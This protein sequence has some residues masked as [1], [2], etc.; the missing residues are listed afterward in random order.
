ML[1]PLSKL[2][3]TVML[4]LAWLRAGRAI[5]AEPLR[6]R[7]AWCFGLAIALRLAL[8]LLM[9]A[10]HGF[11]REAAA[12]L[13][14][15][16]GLSLLWPLLGLALAGPLTRAGWIT[17]IAFTVITLIVLWL[18]G[19]GDAMF[20]SWIVFT[21]CAW[22]RELRTGERF[23]ASLASLVVALA[24]LLGVHRADGLSRAGG[25]AEGVAWFTR[26]L[27]IV[28]ALYATTAAFK[29]FTQD[30]TLGVRRVSRRLVLSHVLVLFVP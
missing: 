26:G 5:E 9:R 19:V 24:L 30:P 11:P 1:G 22:P 14:A 8:E 4:V 15:L 6:R 18:G 29:T 28:Y 17:R 21:R 25:I 23:R 16:L 12:W 10:G 3:I 2:A 27:G 20:W 13:A 7:L